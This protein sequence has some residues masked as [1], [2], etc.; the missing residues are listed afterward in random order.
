M[1]MSASQDIN[2]QNSAADAQN[3]STVA[4]AKKQLKAFW[5]RRWRVASVI[6]SVIV[7]VLISQM[8]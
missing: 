4:Q 1:R 7:L 6:L 8:A 3:N 5:D 2:G